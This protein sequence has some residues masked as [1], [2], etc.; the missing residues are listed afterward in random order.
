MLKID[1]IR[2]RTIDW[3]PLEDADYIMFAGSAR[4]LIDAFRL[5]HVELIEWLEEDYGFDRWDS[6]ALIGQLAENTV[7]NI[8]DPIYTVVA[9]FPKRYLRSTLGLVRSRQSRRCTCP[10][11][12]MVS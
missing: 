3:L 12:S 10:P 6:Y 7:A 4:P 9:R 2:G 11:W 1:L 8:V 5:A